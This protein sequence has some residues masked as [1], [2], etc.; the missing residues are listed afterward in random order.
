V[1]MLERSGDDP[2]TL[3]ATLSGLGGSEMSVLEQLLKDPA[4]T[5]QREAAAVMIAA[6]IA[7]GAQESPSQRLLGTIGEEGRPEWQRAAL[8]RGAEVAL[9]GAA[10]PGAE[11][12]K[13]GGPAAA[14]KP[15]GPT[16]RRARPGTPARR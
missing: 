11:G 13:G 1:G 3:D 10:L 5:A 8:I 16:P 9:L 14:P 12:R 15:A 7:R 2:I 6:T 4:R